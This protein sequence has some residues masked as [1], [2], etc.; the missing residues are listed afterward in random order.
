MLIISGRFLLQTPEERERFVALARRDQAAFFES[1]DCVA[2]RNRWP[3]H[4][5]TLQAQH[6]V[7]AKRIGL[8]LITVVHVPEQ[9]LFSVCEF[10]RNNAKFLLRHF[11]MRPPTR[12]A[13]Y[14]I[15]IL[16]PLWS[17]QTGEQT[18]HPCVMIAPIDSLGGVQL[19]RMMGRR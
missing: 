12:G 15:A 11:G 14:S 1:P 9:V 19:D 18:A 8:K 7:T 10:R 2:I 17:S 4:F 6:W 16:V 13:K 3:D 5:A